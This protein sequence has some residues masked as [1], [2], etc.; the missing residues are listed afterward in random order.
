MKPIHKETTEKVALVVKSPSGEVSKHIISRRTEPAEQRR[1]L[2][3]GLSE[4]QVQR[5]G[6]H[7]PPA[8]SACIEHG[9]TPGD[10]ARAA[11]QHQR[12][13]AFG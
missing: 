13:S 3:L 2:G 8:R 9:E 6:P 1:S 11:Q 12:A 4:Q 10:V 5:R 7:S